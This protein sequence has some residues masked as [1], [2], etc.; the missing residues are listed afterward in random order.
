MPAGYTEPPFDNGGEA[1]VR[2]GDKGLLRLLNDAL[3]SL[4]VAII[5]ILAWAVL[6]LIGTVVPQGKEPAEYIALYGQL[7]YDIM[8]ALGIPDLFHSVFFNL[9]FLWIAV[10]SFYCNFNRLRDTSRQQF[11]PIVVYPAAFFKR[12]KNFREAPLKASAADAAGRTFAALKAK[13]YAARMQE[14]GGAVCVYAHRGM[15]RRWGS[16]VLHMSLVFIIIG[17]VL[18]AVFSANGTVGVLDGGTA[19]LTVDPSAGKWKIIEPVAA[20]AKPT[21]YNLKLNHFDVNWEY[22][23]KFIMPPGMEGA[24][25]DIKRY[26]RLEV[27]QY[28]SDLEVT[29]GGKTERRRV[30]VNHPFVM[31]SLTLYQNS[32]AQV[33]DVVFSMKGVGERHEKV[34][35]NRPFQLVPSTGLRFVNQDAGGNPVDIDQAGSD[36]MEIAEMKAGKLLTGPDKTEVLKPTAIMKVRDKADPARSQSVFLD[37]EKAGPV[38]GLGVSDLTV[39]LGDG[40]VSTSIF[41]YKQAP[42]LSLP[43]LGHIPFIYLG[44][45]AI[46][47][48][49]LLSLYF[50]F[51]QVFVRFEGGKVLFAANMTALTQNVDPLFETALKAASGE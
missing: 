38:P 35:V 47:I 10:S 48:G 23:K 22:E 39:R 20:M 37:S 8:R 4:P 32:Y 1:E 42:G 9:V 3:Q 11:N 5:V 44:F 18:D 15:I 29:H 16:V 40:T 27:S 46:V 33:A 25:D 13:G 24:P 17:G 26:I 36:V 28:V 14:S 7:K 21:T 51:T 49:T 6:T 43:L 34:N 2:A 31:G 30:D 19:A 12:H 45:I 50:A 41:A